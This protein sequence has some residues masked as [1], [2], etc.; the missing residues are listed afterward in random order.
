MKSRIWNL[1]KCDHKI[2]CDKRKAWMDN[3]LL[4]TAI[5]SSKNISVGCILWWFHENSIFI[6]IEDD[7]F[8]NLNNNIILW[9]QEWN[10]AKYIKHNLTDVAIKLWKMAIKAT[11]I[12]IW[13][14]S[15]STTKSFFNSLSFHT[16]MFVQTFRC[17]SLVSFSH[18]TFVSK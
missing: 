18:D 1:W 12:I 13:E 8:I 7:P 3:N 9:D 2:C 5:F 11:H 14:Q 4:H 16:R 10:W 15:S 6:T 17:K